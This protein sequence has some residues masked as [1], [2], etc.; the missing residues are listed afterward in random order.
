MRG[1]TGATAPLHQCICLSLFGIS[2]FILPRKFYLCSPLLS[3]GI[4]HLISQLYEKTSLILTPNPSFAEWVTVFGGAKMTTVLL[5]RIPHHCDIPETGNDS[6][7]FKQRKKASAQ[8]DQYRTLL[9][10]Q[11]SALIDRLAVR[12]L[13]KPRVGVGGAGMGRVGAPLAGKVAHAIPPRPR[14]GGGVVLLLEAF[15]RGPG[16]DQRA[17]DREVIAGKPR[18]ERVRQ[19]W[20]PVKRFWECDKTKGWIGSG[21]SVSA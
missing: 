21:D 15:Q 1:P 19:K 16:V 20:T 5:D 6:W 10:A 17:I 9:P 18:L 12:L 4:T 13:V 7:R 2:S 3:G 14:R 11:Y 8:T